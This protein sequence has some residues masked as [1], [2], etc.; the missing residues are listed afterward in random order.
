M[1]GLIQ[2]MEMGYSECPQTLGLNL[3]RR[4]TVMVKA[5]EIS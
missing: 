5:E 1:F 3:K 2:R 4:E